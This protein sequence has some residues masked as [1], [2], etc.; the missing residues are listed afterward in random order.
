M[1]KN[2]YLKLM[3]LVLFCGW[4]DARVWR[5]L[6]FFIRYSSQLS[7]SQYIQSTECP[8]FF[9]SLNSLEC[10]VSGQLQWRMAWSLQNWKSRQHFFF[11][12]TVVLIKPCSIDHCVFNIEFTIGLSTWAFLLSSKSYFPVY[13]KC[14]SRTGFCSSAL[15][16]CPI[17]LTKADN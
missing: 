1:T 11:F 15:K 6:K 9:S 14:V 10:T 13:R 12:F 3:I 2:R 17:G 5:H 7:K 16:L 8:L 4:E